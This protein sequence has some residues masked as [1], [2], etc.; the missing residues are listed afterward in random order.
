MKRIVVYAAILVA[1]SLFTGS[2]LAQTQTIKVTGGTVEG[3]INDGISTFKGIPFAAP[4]LGDLRWRAPQ[5]V[6]PWEG[7]RKAD[8]FGPAPIQDK[9]IAKMYFGDPVTSEDCLYLNVWTPAKDPNE[10]LPVMV[11]IHG[12][13]FSGGATSIPAYG[14]TAFAK[15][16]VVYVSA[17]YRVGTMGFLAHPDLSKESGKGAGC[18]GILDQVA[19]L[20]WVKENIAKF[21]GDP[22]NV[23]LFGQSAGSFSVSILSTVPS[24]KGL[25][26][27]MICQSGAYIAPVKYSN[28]AGL[29]IPSLKLAEEKGKEILSRLGAD[30]IKE[31]RALS[32]ETIQNAVPRTEMFPFAPVVDGFTIP[33]D[34]YELYQQGKFNDVSVI[35]GFD[36]DEGASFVQ[37]MQAIKPDGF[38]K[39]IRDGYGPAA[40]NLLKVYHHATEAGTFKSQKDFISDPLFGW[41]T[42]ALANMHAQ[43]S[44]NKTYVYYFDFHDEQ[45]P[46]GANHGAEVPYVLMYPKGINDGN[47]TEADKA[48]MD[49]ISSYWINF[50]KKGDPNGKGLPVWPTYDQKNM[51]TM[52]FDEASSARPL[53]NVEKF[54]AFDAYYVWR[55][56]QNKGRK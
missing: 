18:Y 45:S 28:E 7:I 15:K 10:K 34:L 37:P 52:I 19:G 47:L 35:I 4:P 48:M 6:I 51:K 29:F 14:G 41:A 46:D 44:K 20:K 2:L 30:N 26:Q 43:K 11:W 38:E 50:A 39:M 12:G 8:T 42:W 16:G 56:E 1:A 36:S 23:T 13:G 53:P 55:R 21:G 9:M 49:I 22:N 25:F 31:A 24:A 27:R 33:G 3:V 5:P 40:E 32:A 17:T 54:K